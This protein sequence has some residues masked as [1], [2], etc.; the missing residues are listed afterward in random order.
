MLELFFKK[1]TIFNSLS[2]LR[3]DLVLTTLARLVIM[4]AK[5]CIVTKLCTKVCFTE[6]EKF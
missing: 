2:L 5:L 3:K 1:K 4:L 6:A